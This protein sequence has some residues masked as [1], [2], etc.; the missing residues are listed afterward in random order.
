MLRPFGRLDCC[1]APAEQPW[2]GSLSSR[3]L[4]KWHEATHPVLL[5]ELRGRSSHKRVERDELGPCSSVSRINQQVGLGQRRTL[6]QQPCNHLAQVTAGQAY[7]PGRARGTRHPH[8]FALRGCQRRPPLPPLVL[9]PRIVSAASL[10]LRVRVRLHRSRL[11]FGI[12]LTGHAQCVLH[13]AS[14]TPHGSEQLLACSGVSLRPRLASTE[15]APKRRACSGARG[16]HIQRE[17]TARQVSEPGAP[18]PSRR[19]AATVATAGR[20]VRGQC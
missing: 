13:R 5:C 17:R 3:P 4:H 10:L 11:G 16:R 15:L 12:E 7:E 20:T 9:P 1:S 18:Q 2:A 19:A 8:L 14:T 6:R